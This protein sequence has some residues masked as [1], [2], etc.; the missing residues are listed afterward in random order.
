MADEGNGIF[1]VRSTCKSDAARIGHY[2]YDDAT[3]YMDRKKKTFDE[4][5]AHIEKDD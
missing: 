1:T 5:Y 4:V 3:I 2:L